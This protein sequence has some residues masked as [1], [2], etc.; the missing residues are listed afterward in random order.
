MLAAGCAKSPV[1]PE[2]V[3]SERIDP[4]RSKLEPGTRA[5]I[6][7]KES[8]LLRAPDWD[9][10]NDNPAEC[11]ELHQGTRVT[12]GDDPGYVERTQADID[13]DL[14][15]DLAK[16]HPEMVESLRREAPSRH[17][18]SSWEARNRWVRVVVESGPHKGLAG[19]I[20]R[21]HLRP[22]R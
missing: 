20:W 4:E 19:K 2:S 18:A 14:K 15:R 11:E 21:S 12:V 16:R 5:V 22:V 6:A 17:E 1:E 3:A 13:A 10:N 8:G 9:E 7:G